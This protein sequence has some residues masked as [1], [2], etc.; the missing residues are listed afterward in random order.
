MRKVRI[1]PLKEGAQ[2]R[3]E[4]TNRE[5]VAEKPQREEATLRV[6]V[7][8]KYTEEKEY[9]KWALK[10]KTVLDIKKDFKSMVS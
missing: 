9:R 6:R 1:S 7:Y 10:P 2:L 5:V 8:K 3:W 4:K